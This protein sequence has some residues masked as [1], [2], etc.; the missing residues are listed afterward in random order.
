MVIRLTETSN[1]PSQELEMLKAQL[2][3][4]RAKVEE[5]RK[6]IESLRERLDAVS[7]S[8]ERYKYKLAE[9]DNL[10]KQMERES[11]LL[12]RREVERFLVKLINLRDDY[13][14]AIEIARNSNDKALVDGL[15]SILRNL[16]SVLKEEGIKEIEA[17]G[18]TFDPNVHEAVSFIDNEDY[19]DHTITS[20][21]RK[22]YMLSDR[23]IRPSLVEVSRKR[24]KKSE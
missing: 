13:L 2:E 11:Q 23:V 20:E 21:I 6:E 5:Y 14:R 22:G 9:I 1:E 8:E 17:V 19:P 10:R 4:E 16:D 24:N 7:E 3:E 15:Q 12:V 18:K